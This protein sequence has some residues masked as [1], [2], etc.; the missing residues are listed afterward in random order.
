MTLRGS[1]GL[2]SGPGNSAALWPSSTT[3]R[4][5]HGSS[6]G[7]ELKAMAP[8]R[9]ARAMPMVL[10][11]RPTVKVAPLVGSHWYPAPT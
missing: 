8:I 4:V 10:R 2:A 5:I 9:A 6:I 1:G 11:Y 3:A 7:H